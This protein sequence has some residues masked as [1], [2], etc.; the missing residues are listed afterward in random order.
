MAVGT[1]A[2]RGVVEHLH[3]SGRIVNAVIGVSPAP[4]DRMGAPH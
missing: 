3:P 1:N 2:A 4:F